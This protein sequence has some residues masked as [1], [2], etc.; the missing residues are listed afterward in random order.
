MDLAAIK[1]QGPITRGDP[2]IL[3]RLRCHSCSEP[4]RCGE[5]WADVP[6]GVKRSGEVC[7]EAVH[8]DCV[9]NDVV[10]AMNYNRRQPPGVA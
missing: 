6:I 3:M 5:H 7:I 10:R 9:V 4:F 1:C 8:W 2:F